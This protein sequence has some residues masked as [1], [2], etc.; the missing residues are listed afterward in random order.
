MSDGGARIDLWLWHARFYKTRVLAAE[1]ARKGRIR[2]NGDRIDKAGRLVRPGDVLT[3]PVGPIGRVVRVLALAE[4]R[5]PAPEAR[6]LYD[7]LADAI[8]TDDD[9]DAGL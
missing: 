5:G 1:A 2:V 4:R 9:G 6:L 8:K 3:I 7:D